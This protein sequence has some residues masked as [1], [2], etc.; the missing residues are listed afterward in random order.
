MNRAQEQLVWG[1][2]LVAGL[3]GVAAVREASNPGLHCKDEIY[4]FVDRRGRWVSVK[5]RVCQPGEELRI[6]SQ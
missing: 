6:R 3:L 5:S 2:V 4:G 1:G